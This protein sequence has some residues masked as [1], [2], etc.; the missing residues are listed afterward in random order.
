M[1]QRTIKCHGQKCI[2]NSKR[3]KKLLV[4]KTVAAI[5][6]KYFD[7]GVH[8]P[9]YRKPVDPRTPMERL[10]ALRSDIVITRSVMEADINS[11][12]YGRQSFIAGDKPTDASKK[13]IPFPI[14]VQ[15]GEHIFDLKGTMAERLD[16]LSRIKDE[17]V[18]VVT[19][20]NE[21]SYRF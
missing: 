7:G 15:L 18:E 20:D 8:N 1:R 10:I 9:H 5:F 19:M 17:S 2:E 11:A 13:P 6:S 14:A 4:K 16:F 3:H 12:L 21:S